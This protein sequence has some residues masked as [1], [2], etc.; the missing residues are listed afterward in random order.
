MT[1]TVVTNQ[2]FSTPSDRVLAAR[3]GRRSLAAMTVALLFATGCAG[4]SGDSGDP[5][6][7]QGRDLYE[8]NCADCHGPAALG[9]GPLARTL[10][11]QT[12]SLMLHLGHH[13][14]AQLIQLIRGGVPPAMP[15]SSIDEAE[16]RLIVD[17]L[18]TLVPEDEVAALR[19]MQQHMEM[20]GDAPMGSMPGMPGMGGM[21]GADTPSGMGS[22]PPTT[23]STA[24]PPATGAGGI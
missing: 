21:G 14:Q 22:A 18:W 13:T 2:A 3:G 7:A 24:G 19:E 15:P 5:A 16:T 4:D 8:A 9:D 6:I 20:M 1:R 10:P 11:V 23:D 12:P 17:Y